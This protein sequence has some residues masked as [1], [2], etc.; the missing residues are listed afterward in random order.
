MR[1]YTKTGDKGMTGIVGG[2]RVSKNDLIIQTVGDL[3]ELN[4]TLGMALTC[5]LDEKSASFL[6]RVQSAVFDAGAE[7]SSLGSI[8][9]DYQKLIS[10][11]EASIDAM[12]DSLPVMR[13]FILPGG[14]RE[15]AALHL[16]RAVCRRA[17]RTLTTMNQSHPLTPELIIFVNRLSDWLFAAARFENFR[18]GADDVAWM[19]SAPAEKA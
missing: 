8:P 12:S 6:L 14:C 1:L 15:S 13:N 18:R 9:G 10:D 3:D 7:V 2:D 5:E 11:M 4:C 19:K 16:A 17:E